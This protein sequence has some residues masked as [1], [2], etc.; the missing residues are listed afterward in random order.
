MDDNQPKTQ[1]GDV[2]LSQP[3]DNAYLHTTTKLTLTDPLLHRR[4]HIEKQGSQSTVIW[5]PWALGAQTLADLGDDEWTH[6][7][8]VEAANILADARELDA[9]QECTFSATISAEPS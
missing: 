5:N 3:T 7:I 2:V 8:C 9:G 1:H 4:I 6:M